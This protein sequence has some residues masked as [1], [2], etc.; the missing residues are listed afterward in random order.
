MTS[1]SL[2]IAVFPT[3]TKNLIRESRFRVLSIDAFTSTGDQ[4][5]IDGSAR[6]SFESD[7]N[8]WS[9]E[10]R[11]LVLTIDVCIQNTGVFFEDTGVADRITEL[12]VAAIVKSPAS[13][14]RETVDSGIAITCD[15]KA[16]A[17]TIPIHLSGEEYRGSATIDLILYVRRGGVSNRF[18][19]TPGY[20]LGTFQ[21]Y[22]LSLDGNNSI[23]PID[24]IPSDSDFLW[25]LECDYTDITVDRFDESVALVFNENHP[26]YKDLEIEK[27]NVHNVAFLSILSHAIHVLIQ[28]VLS[29]PGA[30]CV[31]SGDGL[32][33]GSVGAAVHYLMMSFGMSFDKPVEL[34]YEIER[35]LLPGV[36]RSGE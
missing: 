21:T 7:L 2:K 31:V 22:V 23:F 1:D 15:S 26:N 12:G 30:D 9:M 35:Y 33:E 36:I 8:D 5:N 18:A 6:L 13:C 14:R 10:E 34:A 25:S 16:M 11:G 27:M 17:F 20:M 28:T 32:S 24:T 3:L 29:E 19:S 4:L